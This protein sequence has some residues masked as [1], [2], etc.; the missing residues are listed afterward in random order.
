MNAPQDETTRLLR[1][2]V[3]LLSL[4]LVSG[5]SPRMD[6]ERTQRE[7]I[8]LLNAVG[9]QSAEIADIVGTT[10]N[11]VSVALSQMKKKSVA[12]KGGEKK[13]SSK[14]AQKLVPLLGVDAPSEDGKF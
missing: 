13:A 6:R 1:I 9:L 11:T 3:R 2:A 10:P 8:K 4:Q 12:K 7:K 5:E 14:K